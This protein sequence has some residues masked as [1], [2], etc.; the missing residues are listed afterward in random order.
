MKQALRSL[1]VVVAL[2]AA[3]SGCTRPLEVAVVTAN[4]AREVLIESKPVITEACAPLYER[5]QTVA[6]L[7][8]VDARCKP[9]VAAYAALRAAW[10]MAVAAIGV[11]QASGGGTPELGPAV[12]EMA[13]GLGL[14]RSALSGLPAVRP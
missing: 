3:L 8:A 4:S 11:A 5:A 9:A 1:V 6:D 7:D 14:M 13:R 10:V 12:A 2:F